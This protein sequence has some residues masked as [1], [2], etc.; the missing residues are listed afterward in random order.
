MASLEQLY[1]VGERLSSANGDPA[2]LQN[3]TSDY[4]MVLTG[5]K[6]PNSLAKRLS[7]QFIARFFADF[8]DEASSALE[9]M[10]DLCEDDDLNIRKQVCLMF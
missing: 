7:S 1:E 6:S 8:P 5:V 2:K 9:A 4:K 3:L 10:L